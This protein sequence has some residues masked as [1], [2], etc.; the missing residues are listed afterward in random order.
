MRAVVAALQQV[1]GLFVEDASFTAGILACV[2]F[3]IFILPHAG[4]RPV[5]RGPA[6]FV[7]LGGVLL[8]NIVR[9]ARRR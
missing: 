5:W 8:E 7:G 1:W 4:L 3:A 2:G 9:S 6:L